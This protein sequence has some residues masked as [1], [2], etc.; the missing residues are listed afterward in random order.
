MAFN[1]SSHVSCVLNLSLSTNSRICLDYLINLILF[2]FFF[3][4]FESLLP[5]SMSINQFI[6]NTAR[7]LNSV[8]E[9]KII[10]CIVFPFKFRCSWNGDI[11]NSI[12]VRI[13]IL[14]GMRLCR[15][16]TLIPSS[17]FSRLGLTA[18]SSPLKILP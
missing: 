2:Y 18:Q 8:T 7:I 14:F 9:F 3:T 6:S 12:K 1:F 4:L 17:D 15:T 5:S 11:W 10:T 16:H 13:K